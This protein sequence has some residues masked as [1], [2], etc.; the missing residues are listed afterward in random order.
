MEQHPLGGVNAQTLEDL[1]VLKGQ[2]DHLPYSADLA[3]QPADVLISDSA[4][5][6]PRLLAGQPDGC[7]RAEEH[8]A[9]RSGLR[10]G[11]VLSSGAKEI[12]AYAVTAYDRDTIQQPGQVAGLGCPR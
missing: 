3:A 7:G 9:V 5:F 6:P 11:E 8:R 10:H 2:L 1:R 12:H 4:P